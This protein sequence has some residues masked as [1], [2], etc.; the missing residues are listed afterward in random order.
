MTTPLMN[1]KNE[2]HYI[3]GVSK[4]MNYPIKK[5]PNEEP[6][7]SGMAD[8][9]EMIPFPETCKGC[10]R[11]LSFE[12]LHQSNNVCPECHYHHPL[13][14]YERILSLVDSGTFSELDRYLTS[15]NPLNFP[16]YQE[17]LRSDREKTSLHEA[18]V[19]GE[20]DINGNPV[21]L[22]VMDPR[23]RMGSMGSVVGEKITRAIET[24]LEK[25]KPFILFSASGGARMQEGILSLMQMAKTSVALEK[26]NKEGILFVSVLTNPT[27][28]GVSA[29]FASLGDLNLAEPQALIG[30]AGRRIIEQTIKE[31]LPNNFQTAEFLLEH[32]QLDMVVDRRE[33]KDTLSTILKI[34]RLS[35]DNA[36]GFKG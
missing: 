27:T 34:H 28:G 26:L 12:D 16:G 19:T 24:S 22:G 25:K 35:G 7:L 9:Q 14:A 31:E 5:H 11:T 20:G 17:K 3:R 15:G 36:H 29:S 1:A 18:I 2:F 23:F 30:F 10:K 32:G 6:L 33:M 13:S 4:N 8:I 21:V